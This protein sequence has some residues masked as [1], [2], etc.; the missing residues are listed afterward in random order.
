MDPWP[1]WTH[2]DLHGSKPLL[3][4]LYDKKKN[5]FSYGI[6]IELLIQKSLTTS[7]YGFSFVP[8]VSLPIGELDSNEINLDIN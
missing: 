1:I 2:S 8:R 3:Y 4:Y 5:V 7:S 6:I